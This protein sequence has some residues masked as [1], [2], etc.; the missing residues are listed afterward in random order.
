MDEYGIITDS[1]S[2]CSDDESVKKPKAQETSSD[3]IS[4]CSSVYLI[5]KP[6]LVKNEYYWQGKDYSNC[7]KED[8]KELEYFSKG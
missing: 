2:E 4:V 6:E 1:E 7:Y 5:Q 3:N 8:F